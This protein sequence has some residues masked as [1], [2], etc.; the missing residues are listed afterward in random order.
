MNPR[1]LQLALSAEHAFSLI[2]D[3]EARR[4]VM[5]D[6]REPAP[7]AAS[8]FARSVVEHRM[9]HLGVIG[10]VRGVPRLELGVPVDRESIAMLMDA[11]VRR[12]PTR[13]I[14]EIEQLED[15]FVPFAQRLW[16]LEDPRP[17]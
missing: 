16:R 11:F 3:P 9:R 12:V 2:G 6:V 1:Y 17:E 8:D 4:Y 5:L 10:M 7:P 14:A 15:D 13:L